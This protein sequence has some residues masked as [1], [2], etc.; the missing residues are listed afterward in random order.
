VRPVFRNLSVQQYDDFLNRSEAR[1][2]VV[3]Y[4]Y[5]PYL[6]GALSRVR[7]LAPLA[8]LHFILEVSPEAW[9][10]NI[11]DM[12]RRDLPDGLIRLPVEIANTFPPAVREFWNQCAGVH[13]MVYNQRRS[14]HPDTWLVGRSLRRFFEEVRPDILHIDGM[15]LRMVPQLSCFKNIAVVQNVHDATAHVGEK[16]WRQT[17]ARAITFPSVRTFLFHSRHTQECFVRHYTVPRER[18]DVA[19]LGVFEVFRAWKTQVPTDERTALFFG[20]LSPYKGLEVFLDAAARVS[21]TSPGW[22]FV[23]AGKPHEGFRIPPLPTLQ[24]GCRLDLLDRYLTTA[25]LTRLVQQA[26]FVVCPYTEAS[27]SGVVLTA[28]AFNKPVIVTNV[29]GLSEYVWHGE[30]GLIIPPNN[31]QAL[32]TAMQELITHPEQLRR[33]AASIEE[34]CANELSWQM[35]AQRIVD[36]Y[37]RIGNSLPTRQ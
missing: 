33:M 24:N 28:Y 31:P 7:S 36:L 30:T 35:S 16:N 34:K 6:D 22:R 13:L 15:S 27:Q 19:P 23:V 9:Q 2:R 14:I 11:F 3:F 26:T 29:G 8:E 10:S 4:T 12:P 25:E 5:T 21:Q 37:S 18:T 20:R 1:M 17:L 32:A